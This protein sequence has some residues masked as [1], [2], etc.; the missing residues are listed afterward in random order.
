M[1]N[2]SDQVLNNNLYHCKIQFY[3]HQLLQNI[4]ILQNHPLLNINYELNVRITQGHR[5]RHK[6]NYVFKFQELIL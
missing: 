6:H 2:E 5:F 4:L 3:M 1:H